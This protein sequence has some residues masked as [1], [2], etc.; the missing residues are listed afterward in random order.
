MNRRAVARNL[1]IKAIQATFD[2]YIPTRV[3]DIILFYECLHHAVRPWDVIERLSAS[4]SPGGAFVLAGEPIND[5]WWPHWG[6]RLDPLSVYC[7]RKFGW[8][9]SGWSITFV[10]A[11]FQRAGMMAEICDDSDLGYAVVAKRKASVELVASR[12]ALAKV[13]QGCGLTG[14][15]IEPDYLVLLGRGSL[16]LSFPDYAQTAL[17]EIENFRA[18]PIK[19]DI[20]YGTAVLYDGVLQPGSTTIQLSRLAAIMKCDLKADVWIPDD[21]LGNGD[22]RSI[23]LHIS[24]LSF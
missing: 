19:L 18:L 9:E 20:Q 15:Q 21:E 8:F 5:A 1:R 3:C 2:D 16:S 23:S 11:M 12:A 17:I 14:W 13:A 24:K 10:I 22:L 4:L 7:I 6:M